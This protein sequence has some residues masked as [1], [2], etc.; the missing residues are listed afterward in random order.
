MVRIFFFFAIVLALAFGVAQLAETPG[1]VT[2]TY[3]GL[4][5]RVTL[6]RAAMAL[7]AITLA[8]M[9]IWSLLRFILRLPSLLSLSNR[10]R[11]RSR[12]YGAVSRGMVS[13]GAGD[14][15]AALRY[16]GEAEK[17]LGAEPLTLLLKAQAAQLA[18]DREGAES[19]FTR[20]LEDPETRVLG[21]RGLYVEARRKGSDAARTYVDEAYRIAP[22]APWAAEAALEYRCADKDWSGAAA[23]VDQNAS[24]RVIPREDA[25]RQ[26][27]VLLAAEALQLAE[28]SPDAALD[29]A[30]RALKLDPGLVPAATLVARRLSAKGDYKSA[31]KA[32]EAAWKANPHPDLAEAYLGVRVGDSTHDR[33]KRA[34]YLLKLTPRDRE[35]RLTVARAAIDARE[36]SDARAILE[37]LVLETPTARACVLMAELEDKE[38]GD[39]GLVRKWLARASYAPRDPAWVADG[40]VADA[41]SPVS[42][43]TGKLDAFVWTTPPQSLESSVRASIDA[44]RF[45]EVAPR[46]EAKALPPAI[47]AEPARTPP[48]EPPADQKP[49]EEPAPPAAETPANAQAIVLPLAADPPPAGIAPA[50]AGV[51]DR[52]PDDPGPRRPEEAKKRWLFG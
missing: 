28:R 5:Y 34:R 1:Q 22:S 15:R 3:G 36:F 6:L 10:M 25:K 48:P 16:A 20:M 27:A 49:V 24:R 50:P 4:E 13:V 47:E 2:L 30:N 9:L 32:I 43:V 52:A 21:L 12:G 37:P 14:R 40:H 44:D 7:L 18:G 31:T 33:L 46:E 41:W 35:A 17:L 39:A 8:L 42:P 19:T 11:K 23:I 51:L 38:H 29:A 45:A 26:K